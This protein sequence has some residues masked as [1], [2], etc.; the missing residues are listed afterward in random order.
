MGPGCVEKVRKAVA[1]GG[2]GAPRPAE[3]EYV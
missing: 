2:L 3:C 1:A